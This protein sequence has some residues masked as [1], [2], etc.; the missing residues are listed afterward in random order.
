MTN[1][2]LISIGF[3]TI[4]HFTVMNNVVFD[5]GRDRHLNVGGVGTPNE[6][7]FICQLD[8]KKKIYSDV[9]CVHNWDYDG[10]LTIEK[11]NDLI[12]LLST[13]KTK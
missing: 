10:S 11:V 5:I 9:I 1:Q 13:P 4:P 3:K 7:M 6:V 8:K 12:N 2:D